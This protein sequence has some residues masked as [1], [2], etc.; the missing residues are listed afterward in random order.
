MSTNSSL[1]FRLEHV[2]QSE[3]HD[4]PGVRLLNLAKRRRVE[5][6]NRIHKVDV[7]QYVEELETQLDT[8]PLSNRKVAAQGVSMLKKDGPS[9]ELKPALP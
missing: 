1:E 2:L 7:V 5:I 6:A 8:L 4:A 9:N 3:L